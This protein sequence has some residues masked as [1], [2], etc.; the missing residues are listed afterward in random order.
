[1]SEQQLRELKAKEQ[2]LN[3]QDDKVAELRENLL[4]QV[5]LHQQLN[6]PSEAIALLER[7][8]HLFPIQSGKY[9]EVRHRLLMLLG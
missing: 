2:L 9:K 6:S 3:E 4:A 5:D 1:M 7:V 8:L